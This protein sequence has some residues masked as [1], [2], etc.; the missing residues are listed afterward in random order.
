MP[1]ISTKALFFPED[2][3]ESILELGE[4]IFS[5]IDHA[6]DFPVG[7]DL[8]VLIKEHLLQAGLDRVEWAQVD[9][10]ILLCLIWFRTP[11]GYLAEWIIEFAGHD[12]AI[13]SAFRFAGERSL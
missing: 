2:D 12:A 3:L 6:L 8:Q 4:G 7:T 9:D 1:T 10:D 11:L 13:I 5:Y